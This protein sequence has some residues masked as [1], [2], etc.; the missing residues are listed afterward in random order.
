MPDKL[1]LTWNL[2]DEV[3]NN[4]NEVLSQEKDFKVKLKKKQAKRSNSQIKEEAAKRTAEAERKKK[5]STLLRKKAAE[6]LKKEQE[7]KAEER[8]R[9][10]AER[11][12]TK[13]D[14]DSA[15]M[16]EWKKKCLKET[17]VMW[18]RMLMFSNDQ[19]QIEWMLRVQRN[20]ANDNEPHS[21][22]SQKTDE[23]G[24][25]TKRFTADTEGNDVHKKMPKEQVKQEKFKE[26]KKNYQKKNKKNFCDVC[27]V[28]TNG[29]ENHD[30]GK[31]HRRMLT[32]KISPEKE[33]DSDHCYP[34]NV[35]S[36]YGSSLQDHISG[37]RHQQMLSKI[38]LSKLET[39]LSDVEVEAPVEEV[40]VL[41]ETDVASIEEVVA[42]VGEAVVEGI[43]LDSNP[44]TGTSRQELFEWMVRAQRNLANDQDSPLPSPPLSP[45]SN[46]DSSVKQVQ[47]K[48]QN[49][50]QEP[51][52]KA[53]QQ[54][55]KVK[56]K[57]QKLKTQGQT[58]DQKLQEGHDKIS[59]NGQDEHNKLVKVSPNDL[60]VEGN[61]VTGHVSADGQLDCQVVA[62]TT[63]QV[64]PNSSK[65]AETK[66]LVKICN[67]C[68][69]KSSDAISHEDHLKGKRHNKMLNRALLENSRLL[70]SRYVLESQIESKLVALEERLF[71]LETKVM[72]VY[73]RKK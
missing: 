56:A 22:I 5:L 20:L 50:V 61:S 46:I 63:N 45:P 57:Q 37:K 34:C 65:K 47:D 40:A 62:Q 71:D 23:A 53:K 27:N 73:N 6:E 51:K 13:T 7:W 68:Q 8:L 1:S 72:Y 64:L 36:G 21:N 14:L 66:G 25:P 10:I 19:D 60:K 4:T 12:G 41:V 48:V 15:S 55:P 70:E 9:M 17:G 54:K 11:C 29:N 26:L 35:K 28:R 49:K 39:G 33:R 52:V 31:R 67:I 24:A 16:A 18:H 30:Q 44:E 2:D 42:Q 58:E 32:D 69:V 59:I 43:S 38:P 3:F